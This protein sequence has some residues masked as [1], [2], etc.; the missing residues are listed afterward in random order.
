MET[1]KT[2]LQTSPLTLFIMAL[3]TCVRIFGET[4]PIISI[5]CLLMTMVCLVVL[6]FLVRAIN[7]E[8]LASVEI[9]DSLIDQALF[10]NWGH[11]EALDAL[12][13]KQKAPHYTIKDTESDKYVVVSKFYYECSELK[14]EIVADGTRLQCEAWILGNVARIT[15]SN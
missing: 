13:A 15:S 3:L 9:A 1:L 2:L 8:E 5:V 10:T 11:S 7:K 4:H 6:V 12:A 14:N